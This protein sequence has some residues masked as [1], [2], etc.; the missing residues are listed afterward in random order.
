MNR[1]AVMVVVLLSLSLWASAKAESGWPQIK[2][3]MNSGETVAALGQ[4]LVR[5]KGREFELWIYDRGAEVVWFRGSVVAWTAPE[6][7]VAARGKQID[8]SGLARQAAAKV[9]RPKYV[10]RGEVNYGYEPVVGHRTRF[11]RY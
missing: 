4:P 10:P 3:G 7:V 1:S 5:S 2:A 9:A 8:L 11:R 6:G